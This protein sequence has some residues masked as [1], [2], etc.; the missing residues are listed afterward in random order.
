MSDEPISNASNRTHYNTPT[1]CAT[2]GK[3]L[4]ILRKPDLIDIEN[5]IR[6]FAK[7]KFE[8][9]KSIK[10]TLNFKN[11]NFVVFSTYYSFV[12]FILGLY[13]GCLK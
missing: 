1:N 6:D 13:F 8:K 3:A 11:R 9:I 2:C 7:E 12:F 10:E 4:F 5:R